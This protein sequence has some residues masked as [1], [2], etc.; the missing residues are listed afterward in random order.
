MRISQTPE[1][2]DHG[3]IDLD[4]GSP[5]AGARRH[6]SICVYFDHGLVDSRIDSQSKEHT[7]LSTSVTRPVDII[8]PHSHRH[9]VSALCGPGSLLARDCGLMVAPGTV[10]VWL[11]L[12]FSPGYLARV[13]I[14]NKVM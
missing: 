2:P 12:D 3:S 11:N 4:L 13:V 8:L 7:H 10:Y 9:S 1:S 14:D 6:I 5:V